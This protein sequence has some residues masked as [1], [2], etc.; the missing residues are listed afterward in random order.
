MYLRFIVDS[1]DPGSD[2]VWS[3][4]GALGHLQQEGNLNEYERERLTKIDKWF[5]KNLKEPNRM[6]RSTRSN[7]DPQALCWFKSDATECLGYVRE[8][9]GILTAHD[10]AVEMLKSD[11]PGYI[12]YEDE[13]QIAAVPFRKT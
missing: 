2:F 7:A 12:V 9:V 3:L 1:A 6:S 13:H 5:V 4:F 11:K 10:I 8:M